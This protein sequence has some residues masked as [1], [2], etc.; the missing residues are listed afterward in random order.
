MTLETPPPTSTIIPYGVGQLFK[1]CDLILESGNG[2]WQTGCLEVFTNGSCVWIWFGEGRHLL[3]VCKQQRTNADVNLIKE[4]LNLKRPN[5]QSATA[6]PGAVHETFKDTTGCVHK[7]GESVR[8][9]LS[10]ECCTVCTHLSL[11]QLKRS[12]NGWQKPLIRKKSDLSD[13]ERGV[14]GQRWE[15][16]D[17]GGSFCGTASLNDTHRSLYLTSKVNL[18]KWLMSV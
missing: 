3:S 16:A 6:K 7:Q 4:N 14:R 18:I 17:W 15:W 5:T 2:A 10:L 12:I 8:C 13:A 11:R 1:L 9:S